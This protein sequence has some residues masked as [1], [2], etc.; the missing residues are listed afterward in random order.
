MRHTYANMLVCQSTSVA[1]TSG[2]ILK[3]L[4]LKGYS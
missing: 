4:G 3:A 2:N 1:T